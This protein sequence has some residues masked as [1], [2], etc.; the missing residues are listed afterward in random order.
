MTTKTSTNHPSLAGAQ[1]NRPLAITVKEAAMT[2]HISASAIYR[3]D[4]FHGPIQFISTVRPIRLDKDSLEAHLAASGPIELKPN[5]KASNTSKLIPAS[6]DTD[7]VGADL[8][9]VPAAEIV[10]QPIPQRAPA[11]KRGPRESMMPKPFHGSFL[12][13]MSLA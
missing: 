13:Y 4:R 6:A 1:S 3:L 2:L 7:P 10:T 12:M 8:T 5:L 11:T 9:S